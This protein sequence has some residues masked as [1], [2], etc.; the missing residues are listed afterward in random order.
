M[1]Y[2]SLGRIFF[3]QKNYSKAISHLEHL[4]EDHINSAFY[5]GFM[6]ENGLGT[7]VNFDKAI[8]YYKIGADQNQ[9]ECACNLALIFMKH[10]QDYEKAD[11]YFEKAQDQGDHLIHLHLHRIMMKINGQIKHND[12]PEMIKEELFQCSEKNYI[13]KILLATYLASGFEVLKIAPDKEKAKEILENLT[14]PD[15][16]DPII[17]DIKEFV[18]AIS[19]RIA[20]IE[21]ENSL[22]L[23]KVPSDDFSLKQEEI[24]QKDYLEEFR[25]K[26]GEIDE[27]EMVNIM[28]NIFPKLTKTQKRLARMKDEPI[29]KEVQKELPQKVETQYP[30]ITEKEKEILKEFVSGKACPMKPNDLDPIINI[31]EKYKIHTSSNHVHKLKYG[32]H[33]TTWHRTHADTVDQAAVRKIVDFTQNFLDS[34]SLV[35]KESNDSPK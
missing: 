13:A 6:W 8:K 26:T 31:F 5:R 11:F 35:E 32:A 17:S 19:D 27:K 20:N 33:I 28:T 9:S 15:D 16:N 30:K 34:W 22:G 3:R 23:E 10:Y 18:Q 25:R 29:E 12:T 24:S 21:K 1:D 4:P 14:L 7:D 2:F